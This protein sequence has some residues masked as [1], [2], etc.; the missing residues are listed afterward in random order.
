[1]TPSIADRLDAGEKDLRALNPK[2]IYCAISGFGNSG[3]ARDRPVYDT[4][5][6]DQLDT[7]AFHA[8]LAEPVR[9]AR[10]RGHLASVRPVSRQFRRRRA[11]CLRF[12]LA[13]K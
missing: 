7:A 10:D 12:Q 9:A 11:S 8:A 3:P 4:L 2:L 6:A 1:M 13:L 5:M